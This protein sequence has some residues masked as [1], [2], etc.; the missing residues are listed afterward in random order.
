MQ[1]AVAGRFGFSENDIR[2]MP[3]HRLRF[4]YEGHTY[5]IEEEKKAYGK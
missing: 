4:W 3:F 2:T 5:M 1:W